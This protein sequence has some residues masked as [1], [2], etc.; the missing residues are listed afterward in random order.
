MSSETPERLLM[1]LAERRPHLIFPRQTDL[2]KTDAIDQFLTE[3]GFELRNKE[4]AILHLR[5][6]KLTGTITATTIESTTATKEDVF[7]QDII[8]AL[9]KKNWEQKDP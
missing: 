3:N 5:K 9:Q 2:A 1:R 7:N 8:L 4:A 6:N